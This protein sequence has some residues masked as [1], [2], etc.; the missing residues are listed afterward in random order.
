MFKKQTIS[1]DLIRYGVV[2]L[3]AFLAD[4]TTL[5]LFKTFLNLNYLIAAGVA[6]VAG[7][8]VNYLLS[9]KWVFNYRK[10]KNVRFELLVFGMIGL[11][12][13]LINEL[14]MYVCTGLL[15]LYFL[16]S[17]VFAT[18]IVFAWNFGVRRAM[19]FKE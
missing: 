11:F 9:I 18:I 16:Y 12:G 6:F 17:K 8:S 7:L 14:V 10:I 4:F 15:L 1:G 3:V 5:Y 19:L 2:G 13:L